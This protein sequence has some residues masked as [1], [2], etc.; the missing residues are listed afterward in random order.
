MGQEIEKG[1]GDHPYKCNA[2]HNDRHDGS[3]KR[4][5]FCEASALH[6]AAFPGEEYEGV[7][8]DLDTASEYIHSMKDMAKV[9]NQEKGKAC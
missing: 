3:N 6:E 2:C 5:G 4:E 1:G 7:D 9:G 8:A